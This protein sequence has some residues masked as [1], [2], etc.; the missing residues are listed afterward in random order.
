[1]INGCWNVSASFLLA[2]SCE[3]C[4][5]ECFQL[6]ESCPLIWIPL[7]CSLTS[8]FW[9][10][11][12]LQYNFCNFHV[13]SWSDRWS[14]SS[15]S[16]FFLLTCFSLL[17]YPRSTLQFDRYMN[18]IAGRFL[19]GFSSLIPSSSKSEASSFSF[20]FLFH[21]ITNF[22]LSTQKV[23]FVDFTGLAWIVVSFLNCFE[24]YC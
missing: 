18:R 8:G 7:L 20:Q 9:K 1:M 14:Q 23:F 11:C 17:N 13:L 22:G 12:P 3:K 16:C 4:R 19:I 2:F 24:N 6:Y 5:W 21:S 15:C 10:N